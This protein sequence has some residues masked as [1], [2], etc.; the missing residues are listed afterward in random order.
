M[1]LKSITNFRRRS[2]EATTNKGKCSD[3]NDTYLIT[4]NDG[5]DPAIV[6]LEQDEYNTLQFRIVADIIVGCIYK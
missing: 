6:H 2:Y 5:V 3:T 1:I 4:G